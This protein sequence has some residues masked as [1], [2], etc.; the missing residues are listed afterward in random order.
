MKFS[1]SIKSF[2]K[3]PLELCLMVVQIELGSTVV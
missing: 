2:E 1:I 3:F